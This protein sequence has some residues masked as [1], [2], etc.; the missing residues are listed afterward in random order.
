[1]KNLAFAVVIVSL[2]LI[3]S[4]YFV[5]APNGRIDPVLNP[6]VIN[7]TTTVLTYQ[8]PN[9]TII[10]LYRL[11]LL[12]VSCPVNGIDAQ[13]DAYF[14]LQ[15][16]SNPQIITQLGLP[17]PSINST[18]FLHVTSGYKPSSSNTLVP[19]KKTL[20]KNITIFHIRKVNITG[21]LSSYLP[22]NTILPDNSLLH[23]FRLFHLHLVNCQ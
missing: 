22:N 7:N 20:K 5:T 15:E 2:I 14:S 13:C 9:Q 18:P 19:V 6:I 4:I 23:Y 8:L 12:N 10:N 17:L 11:T 16:L 21:N 1:M 3:I